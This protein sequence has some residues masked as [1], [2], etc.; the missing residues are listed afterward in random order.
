MIVGDLNIAASQK[1]MH[2]TIRFEGLYH[3]QEVA[4]LQ[5][6]LKTYTD[7]WRLQHPNESES[8]TCWDEKS[9]AR[10]VNKVGITSWTKRQ[11]NSVHQHLIPVVCH[12]VS[13]SE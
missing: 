6:I 3:P 13:D 12:A 11:T 1:D 2:P 7:V 9:F 10:S 4:V 5:S 8:Y